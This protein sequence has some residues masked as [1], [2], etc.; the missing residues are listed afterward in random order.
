MA[1][2]KTDGPIE[3]P[4][5]QVVCGLVA[6][7]VVGTA[8][9]AGC[10]GDDETPAGSPTSGGADPGGAPTGA[11]PSTSASAGGTTLA[12][13]ADVP[14]GGGVVVNG[15]DGARIL[16]L[17]PTAGTVKALDAACTHQGTTVKPPVDGAIVCPN[18]GSKFSAA[19]GSVTRG[20]ARKPLQ[21]VQVAVSGQDV[22]LA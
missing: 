14:V 21:P 17:Q 3:L 12:K 10:G 6:L 16:L 7:G 2:R 20:P 18:H 15:P 5:R 11:A 1:R 22:V 8:V 9:L 4:R 13:V 19:D